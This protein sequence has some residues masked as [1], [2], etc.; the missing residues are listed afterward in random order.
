MIQAHILNL[1]RRIQAAC[2]FRNPLIG[3]ADA[4]FNLNELLRRQ[5][6]ILNIL[7]DQR[8]SMTAVDNSVDATAHSHDVFVITFFG[9]PI[10]R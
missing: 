3:N 2:D 7:L 8:V 5:I 10:P 4:H 1:D 9:R 6:G